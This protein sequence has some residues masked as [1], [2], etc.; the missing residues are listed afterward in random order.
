MLYIPEAIGG[1]GGIAGRYYEDFSEVGDRYF[2]VPGL[3][4]KSSF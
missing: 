3:C 4:S 1:D 2:L